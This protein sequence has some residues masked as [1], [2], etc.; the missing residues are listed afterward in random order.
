MAVTAKNKTNRTAK[1]ST[2]T[3]RIRGTSGRKTAVP[4]ARQKDIPAGKYLSKIV[5]IS[6]K[7]TRNGEDAVEVIYELTAP[8]G[9]VRKMREVIPYDSWAYEIFSDA[10]IAAGLDDDG[11]IA[12][13]VGVTE[14]VYLSYPDERGLG[15]FS[16]RTPVIANSTPS[17]LADDNGEDDSAS[18]LLD[19]EEEEDDEGYLDFEI[20]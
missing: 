8:D 10:L 9:S 20:D 7:K 17:T 14:D 4:M 2:T 1:T 5:K 16:K 15:H 11:D 13:A 6:C 19:D 3:R 12:D 18:G